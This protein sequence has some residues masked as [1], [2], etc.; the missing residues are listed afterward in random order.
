M[1]LKKVI[2]LFGGPNS[3]KSVLACDLFTFMKK[4]NYNVELITEYAKDLT[5]EKRQNVLL[6]DQ[7]YIFAKQHR[8][9]LRIIDNVE[10]AICDSPLLLSGIYYNS[11]H[12]IYSKETFI[13]L[14]LDTFDYYPN[15]NF[16]LTRNLDFKYFT[17]GR[18]QVLD[19]AIVID[20]MIIDFL[21]KYN[22]DC[23]HIEPKN[24]NIKDYILDNLS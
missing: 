14:L 3:G 9:L 4:N 1:K 11:E 18:N 15:L 5:W 24:Y 16:Y 17:E 10:Y 2:N 20:D 23:S 19:E 8:K 13:K 12:N 21:N 7:L 22:I 6:E